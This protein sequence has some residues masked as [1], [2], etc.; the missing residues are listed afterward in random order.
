MARQATK[1]QADSDEDLDLDAIDDD[2]LTG[3]ISAD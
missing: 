2:H 1:V 3:Y